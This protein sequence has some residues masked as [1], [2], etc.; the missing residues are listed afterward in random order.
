M[1]APR[2]RRHEPSPDR[3][4]G[5]AALRI[6]PAT[7]SA[8]RP[9]M[10][11]AFELRDVSK[12]FGWRVE[13]LR[14]VSLAGAPG[15]IVGLLGPNGAGKS[16][17]VKCLAGLVRP[18]AGEARIGGEDARRPAARR[19]L[20]YMPERPA[21]PEY[22]TAAEVLDL[23]GRL[24]G[25]ARAE[26]R[27][28]TA[29]LLD[30]VGLTDAV[31]RRRVRTY[32]KGERAR[33]GVAVALIGEPA[34][35]LFDEPTDGLDPVGRKAVRELLLELRREGRAV[36]LNS[37]L[38]SEVE[39]TCDRVVILKAGR[40]VAAGPRE[41]LQANRRAVYR[42]RLAAPPDPALVDTIGGLAVAASCEGAEL[43]ITLEQPE[44]IDWVVD[45]LREQDASIRELR[46]ETSLEEV[47]LD[48]VGEGPAAPPSRRAPDESA[49]RPEA[50][51]GERAERGEAGGAPAAGAEPEEA[52]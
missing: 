13:A 51:Q 17:A 19:A 11:M 10:G 16:T 9:L 26:R 20:G 4:A 48:L 23:E 7:R 33:L 3:L 49:P 44:E 52:S 50:S 22:C 28:R 1:G 46:A 5:A 18:D 36:L 6:P 47:F 40:V 31:Y 38:L 27:A 21:Y 32:S 35:A 15:E 12:R 39:A 30:R 37:H 14:G 45:F 2:R 25:L 8:I 41:A 24:L 34:V 42:V 29:R 43:T